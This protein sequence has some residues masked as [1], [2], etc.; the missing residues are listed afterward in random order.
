MRFNPCGRVVDIARRTYTT[1][2]RP[3][4]D[5]DEAVQI[6]WYRALPG[7]PTLGFPTRINSLDWC[8]DPWQDRPVGEVADAERAFVPF[9]TPHNATGEHFCGTPE[10]FL[11]GCVLDTSI[12]PVIY[13]LN[14]L[15]LC[16]PD[17]PEGELA[18]AGS[19]NAELVWTPTFT[20]SLPG[21]GE[22][23]GLVELSGV[24]LAPLDGAGELLG[25]VELSGVHLAPLDGAGDVLG[26]VELSG[27]HLAPLDGA[28]DVL[29]LVEHLTGFLAPLDGAGELLGLVEHLTA[30]L[31]PLDGVGTVDAD[32]IAPGP[33]TSCAT[34]G[35]LALGEFRPWNAEEIVR[36]WW[37]A[38]PTGAGTY[39]VSITTVAPD[40]VTN[41]YRGFC[42]S[43]DILATMVGGGCFDFPVTGDVLPNIFA[44]VI[45]TGPDAYVVEIGTGGC[46]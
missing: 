20:V 17:W 23:L 13:R 2:V 30:F 45:G 32:V 12:P 28:G 19:I 27:V 3:F 15:P 34:A 29:G 10:D 18:G 14:G 40:L 25:L 42:P 4:R 31:A 1:E 5:S 43:P 39:H 41:I 6:I 33:G 21:A 8:S 22:L 37:K 26:L 16:C 11:R 24:H 7:A 44:V 9:P 38:E 35:V 36:Q 46:A